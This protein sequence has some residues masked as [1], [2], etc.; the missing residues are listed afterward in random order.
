[1][2]I[3]NQNIQDPTTQGVGGLKGLEGINRLRERGVNI[4]TSIL[5][6][7]DDYRSVMTKI[8]QA[9]TPKQDIGFVGVG[10]S[11]FDKEITSATQLDN[12]ANTR[13]ELQPWYAQIGAGLA[14]GAIL[15]GTTFLDGTIGLVLGAGQAIAEGRG[16]ALW[17][18]PFSKAMQSINEW[19]E[20]ALPNYYTDAERNEPWY[21]NIFTANFL[22]DKFIKNLGFT[23]G[24]FYGGNV[25]GAGLKATK[26]PQIIGAVAK[27][28][29][30][31]AIVTSGVGATISAV[32]EGR[33][34]ALN[35]STDWFNLQKAQLDDKHNTMLKFL[36][37]QYAG[38]EMYNQL[39]MQ[40]NSNYED[41][42][43]KLTEDR[44]KMGNADLLMNIPI[45]TA[46]NLI[47]FGRMYANGF[48]T[49]RKATNIVGKAGEYATGRTTGKGIA[50]AALSPLSEGLEEISQGAASRISGNYY[51]D[52]V[53]NFYK[54]KIDPQAE[55][56]TLSWMKSFAQGINETVNDGSSWEE[57]FIGTLTGALGMPRFRGIRS[58]E[59]KLQSPITLEGG[60][61]GKFR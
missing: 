44:L 40:E 18:N 11:M 53:N 2:A 61:I 21:E 26:L 31:P 4:D 17:D 35:N 30:A 9:T 59:G 13:G 6:L 28:S 22:G 10:D 58:S 27:S 46:S 7:A 60:T 52:D 20:E 5:N 29:R 3:D 49:A 14:K 57:F 50:K 12:L 8:N 32:N 41:T 19:S 23:V 34:E 55:Q 25:I 48:K 38:T 45:L 33:I 54:A 37:D 43:G 51:E 1:M 56:E 16:S 24:A 39:V 47:Q 36:E 42:L 15:A